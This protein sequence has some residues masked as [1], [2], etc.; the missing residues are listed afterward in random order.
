LKLRIP[1]R[2][3]CV[4]VS[5]PRN[6]AFCAC[7]SCPK[8][9]NRAPAKANHLFTIA[10]TPII[11]RRLISPTLRSARTVGNCTLGQCVWKG[12]IGDTGT[13]CGSQSC[14]CQRVGGSGDFRLR[15]H[16]CSAR[17]CSIQVTPGR[18]GRNTGSVARAGGAFDT[19]IAYSNILTVL[20]QRGKTG[21][22][23]C[24][25]FA[26]GNHGRLMDVVPALGEHTDAILLELRYDDQAIARL[27]A[28]HLI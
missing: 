16:T 12:Y 26:A 27:H 8:S 11:R 21:H 14:R 13:F 3:P 18:Y 15:T 7:A 9:R 17:Q 1:F 19:A 25:V 28:E 20:I 10:P 22:G 6:V 2:A 5:V 4:V 24:I 23:C